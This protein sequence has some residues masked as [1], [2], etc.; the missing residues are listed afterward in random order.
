MT[1]TSVHPRLRA[2]ASK[3]GT[4]LHLTDEVELHAALEDI[5][6]LLR[7]CGYHLDLARAERGWSLT[8]RRGGRRVHRA[9]GP[10]AR[11]GRR[12]GS[13]NWASRQ[14]GLGLAMIWFEQ[15]GRPPTRRFDGYGEQGEHGPYHAFVL[16]VVDI[17][18]KTLRATRKGHTPAVDHLVRTS[19]TEFNAARASPDEARR[20][21]LLD[22]RLWLGA[23]DAAEHPTVER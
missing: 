9:P 13:A 1:D 22:A 15:T 18:P 10:P 3:L 4:H 12:P 16:T 6:I 23:R 2:I 8:K 7:R 5:Q 20:R 14:L 21:G 17:L 19:I 11:R